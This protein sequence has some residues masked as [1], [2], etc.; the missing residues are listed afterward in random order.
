I[1]TWRKPKQPILTAVVGLV[2][3]H[4]RQGSLTI[5]IGIPQPQHSN[6]RDRFAVVVINAS[7]YRAS[8]G[9]RDPNILPGSASLNC[10]L[11]ASSGLAAL[12]VSAVQISAARYREPISSGGNVPK[13][14]LPIP[15][16][17]EREG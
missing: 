9:H 16:C 4:C 8:G 15:G 10:Q 5:E 11:S 13:F 14:K 7:G 1:L 17:R 2:C 12:T 3:L 6:V